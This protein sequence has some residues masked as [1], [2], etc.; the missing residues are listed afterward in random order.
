M[1]EA[2]WY[3][4]VCMI[5]RYLLMIHVYPRLEMLGRED[6]MYS[7]VMQTQACGSI[8]QIQASMLVHGHIADKRPVLETRYPA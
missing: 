1:F 8:S 2:T 6:C 3:F 4:E 5:G 7:E